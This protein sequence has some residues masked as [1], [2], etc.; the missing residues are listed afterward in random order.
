MQNLH[1]FMQNLH[2]FMQN[3][4]AWKPSSVTSKNTKLLI[5]SNSIDSP[6][7]KTPLKLTN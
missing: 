5:M 4:H 7:S 3:L 6:R 1:A 2:A